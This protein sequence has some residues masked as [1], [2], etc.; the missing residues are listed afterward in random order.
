[1][2]DAPPAPSGPLEARKLALESPAWRSRATRDPA[3]LPF[4]EPAWSRTLASAYGLRH[5]LL[6]AA[7][8]DGGVVDGLP[9]VETSD[10]LRGRRWIGLPFTDVCPPLV[11]SGAGWAETIRSFDERRRAAGAR[12]LEIRTAIDSARAAPMDAGVIH[13][14]E[15]GPDPD[16]V[17]RSFRAQT[18]RNIRKAV[19]TGVSIEASRT[20][21][22]LLGVFYGLH[23]RTRR[24]QGI[25][26]QPKR[27]F[28]ALRTHMLGAGHGFVLV[29]R[30][31]GRP[32]AAAVFL[33]GGDTIVYK[34]GASDPA[35]L[36]ARPNNLL[37]WEAIRWGCEHG[38]RHFNF[39][40]SDH[41][42]TG[43]RAFKSGWG[44]EERPLVYSLLTDDPDAV[45]RAYPARPG[46]VARKL[47]GAAPLAVCRLLGEALYRYAA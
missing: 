15:L 18:Q 29:A 34:F 14:L 45:P 31:E 33:T 22:D 6:A 32:V 17:F 43:L 47:I 24:R 21:H 38:Y 2:A 41:E 11:A 30:L 3:W 7:G 42:N 9:V 46:R 39:G 10:P 26:V 44:A 20:E 19:R 16:L 35:F 5:F 4:H 40:R 28:H 13:E 1:M 12:V 37:F 8:A 25:P 27:F 36:A 23:L